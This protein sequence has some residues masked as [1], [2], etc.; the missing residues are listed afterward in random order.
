MKLTIFNLSAFSVI[1]KNMS[2]SSVSKGN[3]WRLKTKQWFLDKG[4]SCEYLEK[5]QRL[6]T[7]GR[8]V[9]IKKDIFGADGL[10]MDGDKAIFWQCKLG[11]KNI[12]QAIKEFEK[13]P[14]P[15][16]HNVVERWIV[17]WT[18][19]KKEPEVIVV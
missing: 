16:D 2:Q 17:V 6:Y 18:P 19:R 13:Y 10:A 7:K 8:I 9:F 3:Y 12:A 1:E 4:Y 14:Y 15:Y 5:I 11:K